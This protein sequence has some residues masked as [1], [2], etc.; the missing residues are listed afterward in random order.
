MF[1][2]ATC[3]R[4]P[5]SPT[6]EKKNTFA[7]FIV[8]SYNRL[9]DRSQNRSRI[10]VKNYETTLN[11]IEGRDSLVFVRFLLKNCMPEL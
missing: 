5:R 10:V 7:F 8:L 4:T 3:G 6:Q 2:L 9:P 11:G 1:R